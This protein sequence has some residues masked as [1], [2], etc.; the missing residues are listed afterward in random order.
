MSSKEN[1]HPDA[2]MLNN[3]SQEK[4]NISNEVNTA[5]QTNSIQKI[6]GFNKVA[7]VISVTLFLSESVILW[8]KNK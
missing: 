7:G 6:E 8:A 5:V 3:L 1:N 4:N 2:S